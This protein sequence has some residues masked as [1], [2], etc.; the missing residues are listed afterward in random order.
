MVTIDIDITSEEIARRR[1]REE[2]ALRFEKPDRIPVL[3]YLGARYWLP[4]I[5]VSFP[6]YFSGPRA[7]LEAQLRGGKWI[8]ENIRSDYNRIVLVPDFMF[9][10]DASAFGGD[11]IFPDNDSP[12]VARPHLLQKNDDL[13][14]LRRVDFV[15]TGLH[16][17][18]LDWHAK[19]KV[20]AQ[21][22]EIRFRDGVRL[23]A[24]E[25]LVMAGSGTVGLTCLAG[26][27][28][29]VE[30]LS[31]DFYERPEWV[32]ELLDIILEK[33]IQW[34]D[35]T[36][37]AGEGRTCWC[38][39]LRDHTVFL[40][41]DGGAQMSPKHF[42]EYAVPRLKRLAD[43]YRAKGF[44]IEAHNCGKADHL[45]EFW[46][47]EIG[48]DRYYGFS[49]RTDKRKLAEVMAGRIVLIGGVSTPVL[50][51]GTPEEV[52]ED[53]RI[54]IETIAPAASGGFILMDGHNVAPGTPPENLSAM[55][56]AA[57][58][59]GRY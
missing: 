59:Y 42:A 21:E 2:K 13:E 10:E 15:C 54:A 38:N 28:R 4:H 27:L 35:A 46:A 32:R 29:G 23:P 16:G 31:M 51:K 3:H 33:T 5:G 18:L 43:Y 48:I 17:R 56:D 45:L 1:E 19:M 49:Y 50:H 47:N 55:T 41:D 53:S 44:K 36:N 6:E 20:L 11:V 22:Y 37:R 39:E 52:I 34:V 57:E 40:G 58:R 14:A 9:V 26:D 8:L 7:Q 30:E 24:S 12:W 25:C